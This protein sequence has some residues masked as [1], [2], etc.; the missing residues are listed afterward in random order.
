VLPMRITPSVLK[1]VIR[2]PSTLTCSQRKSTKSA[3]K[4]RDLPDASVFASSLGPVIYGPVDHWAQ[5]FQTQWIHPTP[6]YADG[7]TSKVEYA[8]GGVWAR[9]TCLGILS[10]P[11]WK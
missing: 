5:T 9:E 4:T 7:Q 10:T 11:I 1:T 6:Q 2:G 8:R 3:K